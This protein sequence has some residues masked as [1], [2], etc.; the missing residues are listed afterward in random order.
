M[1]VRKIIQKKLDFESLLTHLV[2][3]EKTLQNLPELSELEKAKLEHARS[4][5]HLYHSTK[6]EGTELTK[7]RIDRAVYGPEIAP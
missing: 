7:E 6:I 4:I 3:T 2:A 1:M 5:E